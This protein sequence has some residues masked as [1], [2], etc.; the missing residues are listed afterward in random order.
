MAVSYKIKKYVNSQSDKNG[1]FYARAV[2]TGEMNLDAV[3]TKI[4]QNCS[5]KKSDVLAVVNELVEVI[6]E[7]VQDSK[8]VRIDGL[9]SFKITLRSTLAADLDSFSANNIKGFRVNFMP[10]Y[11][12]D[13]TG[14]RTTKILDGV[15]AQVYDPYRLGQNDSQGGIALG[16]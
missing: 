9:G 11:K 16:V 6:T 7:A 5:M 4:Q 10:E 3:A 8:R 2:V 13:A 12:K 1:Q 14:K 15:Q